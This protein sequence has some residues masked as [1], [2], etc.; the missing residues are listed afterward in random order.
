MKSSP[1]V[2]VGNR[3]VAALL[4]IVGVVLLLVNVLLAQQNKK[5]RFLASRADRSLEVKVGTALQ[6]LEGVDN[7]GNW[8][9]ISYGQDAR[10]TVLFIF[11]PRCRACEANSLNWEAVINE[12]DRQSFRL[13]GISL[14]SQGVKEYASR[15]RI[16]GVPIL[17]EIDAKYRVAYNLALTPQTILIGS[18]GKVERVW[19][20]V[21]QGED[22]RDVER[23]L[24]VR[25]P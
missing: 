17:T 9:S 6:S 7:D 23:A 12:I 18:D 5:L 24:N 22:K 16:N 2:C 13:F 25:L 11:S 14:Q 10:K 15:H 3:K 20:G 21:L 8:Q 4:M 19:T 1:L